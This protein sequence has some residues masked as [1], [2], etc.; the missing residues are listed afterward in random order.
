M[1]QPPTRSTRAESAAP[2]P[3]ID[4]VLAVRDLLVEFATDFGVVRAADGVSFDVYPNSTLAVVGE[5]GSGKSVS[6]LAALGLLG[7]ANVR[8]VS[9]EVMFRGRNLLALEPD[10]RRRLLGRDISMIFQDPLSSLNPVMRVGDQIAEV[11]VAHHRVTK[12]AAH[13]RAVELLEMVEV[14]EPATRARQYPH[15]FS[16]GMRQ[17]VMV[18]IA[19]A[20]RPAV[21]IADEP[22]TALDVTVQAQLL[23]LLRRLQSESGAGM[24]L[25]THDMGV[26]AEAADRV[27][28]MY[29]GRIMESGPTAEV[30]ADPR[31]PYTAA[32]LRCLPGAAQLGEQLLPIPGQPPDLRLLGVGCP[33]AARCELVREECRSRRPPLDQVAGGTRRSACFYH[34]DVPAWRAS[35]PS[36][37]V[38]QADAR[39][40]RIA[41][42]GNRTTMLD[43]RGLVTHFPIRAGVL[44]RP[45]GIIRA[46]DGVDMRVEPGEALGIV[47]ESGCGKTTA[48]RTVVRL[49]DPTAGEVHFDGTDLTAASGRA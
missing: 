38:A 3:L 12:A 9:G 47:G 11:V 48:L 27:S 2:S 21:L 20:N 28:I 42:S 10:E 8:R 39:E 25:I 40:S 43:V 15:E 35:R 44:H 16:G 17:R 46:V 6:M 36:L 32:L 18:A 31:H 24:V 7:A 41:A 23:D 22:T 1:S 14:P 33:F 5:T 49:V 30:L 19:I 29:G 4:P 37:P 34:A 45:V 13:Q 26:V